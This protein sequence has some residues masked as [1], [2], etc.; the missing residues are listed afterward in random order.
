MDGSRGEGTGGHDLPPGKSQVALG[1]HKNTGADP[2]EKH[3]TL[4]GIPL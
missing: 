1:F 4:W 3:W 2:L